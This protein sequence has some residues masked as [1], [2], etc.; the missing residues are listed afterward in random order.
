[1]K[2]YPQGGHAFPLRKEDGQSHNF[3]MTLRDYIAVRAMEKLL[4]AGEWD[5]EELAE[6]AFDIADAM[7]RERAK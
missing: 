1:M 2:Q 7:L 6:D 4:E 3:G 5:E